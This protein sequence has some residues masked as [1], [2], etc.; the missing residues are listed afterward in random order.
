MLVLVLLIRLGLG[1]G[2]GLGARVQRPWLKPGQ[3][4]ESQKLG[5]RANRTRIEVLRRVTGLGAGL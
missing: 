4:V 2:L 5:I 1:L 3:A